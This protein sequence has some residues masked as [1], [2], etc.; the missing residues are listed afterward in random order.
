V[1]RAASCGLKPDSSAMF[2]SQLALASRRGTRRP[3]GWCQ[4]LLHRMQ[5]NPA[6]QLPGS[7][8][9]IHVDLAAGGARR[10]GGS[11]LAQA[12][13]QVLLLALQP[14]G[15]ATP[16]F[17]GDALHHAA[18]ITRATF[19]GLLASRRASRMLW[20]V[21]DCAATGFAGLY[22]RQSDHYM[23]QHRFA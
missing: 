7:G 5:V 10:L 3:K 12:F 1:L 23:A 22:C 16:T 11:C 18:G 13:Q 15:R 6:L 19:P 9:L 14:I 20:I 4:H 2:Q 8:R 21:K 17:G